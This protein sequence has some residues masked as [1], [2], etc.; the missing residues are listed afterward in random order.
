MGD[1]KGV[2]A[3]AKLKI[4]RQF[5]MLVIA[6]LYFTRIIVYMLEATVPYQYIWFS[7][8]ATLASYSFAGYKFRPVPN[9][10]YL[11]LASGSDIELEPI[12]SHA[13]RSSDEDL[14]IDI[15]ITDL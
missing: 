11:G 1:G 6:W 13:I 12:D 7:Y 4:F 3:A 14:A 15:D 2:V 5:Y 10:P 9:N 8:F